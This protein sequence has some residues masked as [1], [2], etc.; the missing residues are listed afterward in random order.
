MNRSPVGHFRPGVCNS[1]LRHSHTLLSC[2][3]HDARELARLGSAEPEAEGGHPVAAQAERA[4]V[5]EVALA[6]AFDDGDDVIGLP[7][8]AAGVARQIPIIEQA[9]VRRAA[10]ALQDALGDERVDAATFAD[11]AIAFEHPVAEVAGV[12]AEPP[13][14]HALIRAEGA[15]AFGNFDRAPA[16]E[17]AAGGASGEGAIGGGAS[18]HGAAGAHGSLVIRTAARADNVRVSSLLPHPSPHPPACVRKSFASLRLDGPRM[19]KCGGL[20]ELRAKDIQTRDL[21]ARKLHGFHRQRVSV[22]NC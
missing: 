18:G 7:E 5:R 19:A 3:Y 16:A 4:Q 12:G 17:A 22:R 2:A 10:G 13:F 9:L 8:G 1:P 11:A 21:W 6:A 15:A 14:V 20:K